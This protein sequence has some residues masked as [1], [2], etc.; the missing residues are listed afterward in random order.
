M[1]KPAKS[2]GV[3]APAG[4]LANTAELFLRQKAPAVSQRTLR[5]YRGALSAATHFFTTELGISQIQNV[6]RDGVEIYWMAL[7]QRY[8]PST[9]KFHWKTLRSCLSMLVS[10]GLLEEN[11][12]QVMPPYPAGIQ[13]TFISKARVLEAVYTLRDLTP[14]TVQERALQRRDTAIL[15]MLLDGAL[16]PGVLLKLNLF[17]PDSPGHYFQ[18]TPGGCIRYKIG[19]HRR[20]EQV[21]LE[22]ATQAAL[23]DYL[24][25]RDSL[26]RSNSPKALFLSRTGQRLTA[27]SLTVI[28]RRAGQ[29][30]G[31]HNLTASMIRQCRGAE[32]ASR[33][34][35][36]AAA[37]WMGHGSIETTR[38]SLRLQRADGLRQQ[39]S[40]LAPIGMRE[41]L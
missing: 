36:H 33:I 41:A 4:D 7:I 27:N 30:V 14:R 25:I 23:K 8:A 1:I 26:A 28:V 24:T 22:P 40:D 21:C 13:P 20:V 18:V 2:K 11:P 16:R 31:I 38:Q 39:V 5:N 6:T 34:G 17:D 32:I 9:A 15:L 3:L 29:R 10:F 12:T 19:K 37:Q 35:V